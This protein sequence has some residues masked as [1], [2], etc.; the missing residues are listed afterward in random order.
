VATLEGHE[1][2]V[3]A[4]AWSEDGTLLAS[5]SR[6]KSVWLWAVQEE[7]DDFE[8][9]AVLHGH[10]QD[11]KSLRWR[12]GRAELA[13][14]SYDDT[15][16]IWCEEGGGEADEWG[17]KETLQGHRSTVWDLAFDSTGMRLATVSEDRALLLWQFAHAGGGA[18]GG[19]GDASGQW[20]LQARYD[21]VHQRAIYSVDWRRVRLPGLEPALDLIAT[22]GGDDALRLF[23]AL[24]E[25]AELVASYEHVH[26]A[27]VNCVRF[28]PTTP[29]LASASDD[30]T[31]RLWRLRFQPP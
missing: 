19:G 13:S 9:L 7:Q 14:A 26:Q 10:S 16:R 11:V 25:G 27:D 20:R 30:L 31:V 3:K 21:S 23:R 28:H 12:P 2:E 5:C 8:C 29:L 4:L 15:V 17:C 24:P 6:D 22:A 18:G 1:H